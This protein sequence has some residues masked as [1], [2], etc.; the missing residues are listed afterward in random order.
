M[1]EETYLVMYRFRDEVL[2]EIMDF[3][4]YT[5]FCNMHEDH[6]NF[7]EEGSIEIKD[8]RINLSEFPADTAIAIM[9][10]IQ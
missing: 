1:G 6:L 2:V 3:A 4:H 5:Q 9:G 7:L 10:T 8:M